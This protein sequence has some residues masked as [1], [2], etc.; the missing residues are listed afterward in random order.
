[1]Q[2]GALQNVKKVLNMTKN[3]GGLTQVDRSYKI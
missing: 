2:V 3:E 1:M